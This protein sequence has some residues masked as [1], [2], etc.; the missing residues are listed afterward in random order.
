MVGLARLLM[1]IHVIPQS[2]IYFSIVLR[3]VSCGRPHQLL[4]SGVLRNRHYIELL[5]E[6]FVL[7]SISDLPGIA[8]K[9]CVICLIK[10]KILLV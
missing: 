9:Y 6:C 5:S 2:F 7:Y 10:Q 1:L 4:P 8:K 3:H